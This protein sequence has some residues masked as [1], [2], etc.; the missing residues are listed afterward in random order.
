MT[1]KRKPKFLRRKNQAYKKLGK[2]N[3]RMQILRKPT[4]RDNKMREKRKGYPAVVSIG[5]KTD[6]IVRGNIRDKQPVMIYNVKDL[7][8]VKEKQIAI[9]AHV[10]KK[11]RLEISK[12]A[13]EMKIEV[14]NVNVNKFIKKNEIKEKPKDEKSNKK[15][16]E[17]KK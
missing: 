6:K 3:K 7:A 4:G 5:Y 10:G 16:K 11:K 9:I 14:H 2:R 15:L 12:K 8:N 1:E 17:N 13:K